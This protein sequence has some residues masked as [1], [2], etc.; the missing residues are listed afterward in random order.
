MN[1]RTRIYQWYRYK[2][3][4]RIN[5]IRGTARL[6]GYLNSLSRIGVEKIEEEGQSIFEMDW[7]NLIILDACRYDTYCEVNGPTDSRI[8]LGSATPEYIEKTYSK[9]DHSDLVYVTA[10]PHFHPSM[11]EDLTD[12][13]IED[14]FEVV[15]HTYQEKWDDENKTVM[16]ESVKEDA[17]T[18][19]KL[20]PE[21]KKVIHFMQPHH[22]FVGGGIVVTGFNILG[23]KH[24]E[25]EWSFAEMGN[26]SH[27]EVEEAYRKNLEFVMPHVEE[28]CDELD[29]KTIVT[30]DHGNLVGE[31][32]LYGHPSNSEAQKLRKVPMD[33]R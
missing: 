30:S 19:E 6:A 2:L 26:L 8:S 4:P 12:R 5:Y 23:G 16:P 27:E 22:P 11:F 24:E 10:N 31:N 17:L 25:N 1:L 7:D 20:Y 14:T 9:E 28:L 3:F 21:N 33:R 15:F 13:E 29:G 18:A 32:G